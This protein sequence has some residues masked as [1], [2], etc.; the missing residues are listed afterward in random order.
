MRSVIKYFTALLL[1][2]FLTPRQGLCYKPKT[3]LYLA[4]SAIQPIL[5]GSNKIDM[6]GLK[7]E[8]DPEMAAA[9]REYPG[10]YLGGVVGPD[11]F[12][13]IM[14]GQ[15]I[16]HPDSK[17]RMENGK[18]ICDTTAENKSW[19]W[20]W[21]EHLYNAAKKFSGEERKK[22][23]A[24]VTGYITHGAGDMWAHTFVNYFAKG[25][26]PDNLD[27]TDNKNIAIRHIIVE[28]VIGNYT[29]AIRD[30]IAALGGIKAPMDFIVEQFFYDPWATKR[31][32]KSMAGSFLE[33][34]EQLLKKRSE[35]KYFAV[36]S[37]LDCWIEEIDKGLHDWPAVSLQVAEDLFV[38]EQIDS[39]LE[40]LSDFEN[41]HLY[42]M[43]SIDPISLVASCNGHP[44][45]NIPKVFNELAKSLSNLP[46]LKQLREIKA[47]LRNFVFEKV[48]GVSID[49]LKNYLRDPEGYLD[50][51]KGLFAAGDREKI[52][53]LICI[54]SAT[55]FFNENRFAIAHNTLETCKLIFLTPE[56]LD[57]M[58]FDFNVGPLYTTEAVTASKKENV[59]LGFI[60][61]L[62]GNHQWR[63]VSPPMPVQQPSRQFS[64]EMPLWTDCL[65]RTNFFKK[66]FYEWR[67]SDISIPYY[68][69]DSCTHLS[70]LPPVT[71]SY[72]IL[73]A[74]KNDNTYYYSTCGEQQFLQVAL[75]NHQQ[76]TQNYSVYVTYEI[77][78]SV[79]LSQGTHAADLIPERLCVN[80]PSP[81]T[82]LQLKNYKDSCLLPATPS[83]V[84]AQVVMNGSL[85]ATS[86]IADTVFIKV[87]LLKFLSGAYKLNVYLL[88]K[89]N[90]P[91]FPV[92][93]VAKNSLIKSNKAEYLTLPV[94][95]SFTARLF[96]NCGDCPAQEILPCLLSQKK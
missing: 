49:S 4:L 16:I 35:K 62:D 47:N 80:I 67:V 7:Y 12:P 69:S 61:S 64:D 1:L 23:L 17:C 92:L 50:P 77:S 41:E 54:D 44:G 76:L 83:T 26:W 74:T 89:M 18:W 46:G 81:I 90:S 10:Y 66:I 21:F 48:F 38:K 60:R 24:F 27:S 8:I 93:S 59:M 84:I 72:D 6:A 45:F 58:L 39:A 68:E 75:V 82:P 63:S 37:Y 33:L 2:F 20:E 71:A 91:E 52:F 53:E 5:Q 29:P 87:P 86:G 65:A 85:Q 55:G 96:I 51:A 32:A 57:Q 14:F 43:L 13:D 31:S 95:T 34:K 19:S 25:S 94:N 28:G 73:Q 88:E 70:V 78:D 79:T 40:R 56:R 9:I 42:K 36:K 11:G 22:A 15:M 30:Q 3:H